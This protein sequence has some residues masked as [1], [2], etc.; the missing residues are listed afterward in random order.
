MHL[1]MTS[2]SLLV[3]GIVLMLIALALQNV[4]LVSGRYGPVLFTALALCGLA[5]AC[6]LAVLR[7]GSLTI[8]LLCV[9]LMLPTLYLLADLARRAPFLVE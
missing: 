7:R 1:V 4:T 8:R 3:A 6:F 5:D 9:A 2:R